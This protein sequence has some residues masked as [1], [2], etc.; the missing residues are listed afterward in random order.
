MGNVKLNLKK[1]AITELSSKEMENIE[2][3][4]GWWSD[5][6]TGNCNYSESNP[7]N[8][9]VWLYDSGTGQPYQ[10]EVTVGCVNS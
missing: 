1:Q 5:Y 7:D 10:S 6:R 8:A 4:K 2:G 3:G 9:C